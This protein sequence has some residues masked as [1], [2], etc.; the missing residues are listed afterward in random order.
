MALAC[1][2]A[3]SETGS[4]AAC[5]L[6]F[7]GGGA[8]LALAGTLLSPM[9]GAWLADR[10][11]DTSSPWWLVTLSGVGAAAIPPLAAGSLLFVVSAT[12]VS[13]VKG[14]GDIATWA[15]IGAIAGIPLWNAVGTAVGW[16]LTAEPEPAETRPQK[17]R[18][19]R[20]A[21]GSTHARPMA[22]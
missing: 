17:P 8:T 3:W 14:A 9:L 6:L 2:N 15:M 22:Y 18:A 7:I 1:G 21:H 10:V 11:A 16:W 13:N 12:P 20:H 5:P 19:A 4:D